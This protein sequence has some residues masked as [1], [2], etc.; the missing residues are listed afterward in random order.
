MP[1]GEVR[2]AFGIP[3]GE[4]EQKK[5]SVAEPGPAWREWFYFEFV[6]V[7]GILGLLV[8]DSWL[9]VTFAVPLNLPVLVAGLAVAFYLEFLLYRFL[10]YRPDPE[11]SYQRDGFRR[12]WTRPAQFGRWTTEAWRAREGLNPMP[13]ARHG[14]DPREFL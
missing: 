9:A 3:P 12:T 8:A 5:R 10:W 6:K 2:E 7:W 11:E 4:E 13:D 1:K 14:P